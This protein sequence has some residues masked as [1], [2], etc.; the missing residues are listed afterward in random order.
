VDV[1]EAVL[2][3][4]GGLA[5]GT[6]NAIIGSGTLITFPLL[7]AAGLPPVVANVTNT[8]G[9]VP[10]SLT[11]VAA[12]RDVL[13]EHRRP[14]ARLAAC[15]LAGSLAGAALLLTLPED[16][17]ALAAPVLVLAALVLVVVQP[18][19][20]R[21]LAARRRPAARRGAGPLALVAIALA[22]VYGGYFGA[23]Q[24]IVLFAILATALPDDL[25][26]VNATRNLLAAVANGVAAVVFVLVAD[27]DWA[28]AATIAVGAAAGGVLGARVGRRLSARALRAVVVVVG[29]A[30]VVQLV[31]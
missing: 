9:L 27:V 16:A 7:L 23:A 29:L 13:A 22:G 14:S 1:S 15:S 31:R 11:A 3:L 6:V 21:A 5:A 17:F 24:G 10:G 26:R 28:A 2:V 8:V 20:A 12:Y 30:A 19:L 4:A 18:R 25:P